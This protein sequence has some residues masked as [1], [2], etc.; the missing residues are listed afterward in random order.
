M[1]FANMND[2]YTARECGELVHGEEFTVESQPGRLWE[3]GDEGKI[4]RVV[5]EDTAAA[6]E[7]KAKYDWQWRLK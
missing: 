7:A 5:N 1:K 4:V 2:A 6:I 3:I